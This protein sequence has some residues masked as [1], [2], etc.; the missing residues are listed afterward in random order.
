MHIGSS[1]FNGLGSSVMVDELHVSEL[2]IRIYVCHRSVPRQFMWCLHSIIRT[3]WCLLSIYIYSV[4]AF[5]IIGIRCWLVVDSSMLR[6]PLFICSMY[7]M[8][9]MHAVMACIQHRYGEI[10]YQPPTYCAFC[11]VCMMK[12]P[13][14]VHCSYICFKCFWRWYF[15]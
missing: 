11:M 12:T 13:Y 8:H 14:I 15:W 1:C 7:C 10:S 6:F 2:Y 3:A 5:C 9:S 4:Y